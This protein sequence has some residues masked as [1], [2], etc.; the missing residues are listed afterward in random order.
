MEVVQRKTNIDCQKL[1]N[2]KLLFY[3][4]TKS[5]RIFHYTSIVGLEGILGNRTLRFTNIKYMNDKDEIIAG[6]DSMAKI[7]H[8][9]EEER[10]KLC[11]SFISHGMQTFVCCFSVEEDSLPMWNYY[12]KE[13]NNQGYNI[14][15]DD[16]QLVESILRGND[17]LNGCS[18]A[19]GIVDYSKD[20]DSEYSQ[21]I[22]REMLSA[23]DLAISKLFLTVA[24][25]AMVGHSSN[26]D[27]SSL[28]DWEKRIANTE[29]RQKLSDLP[30]YFYNGEKCRF[31]KNSS[32]DYLYF[33]KRDCFRQEREFRIVITVPDECLEG[34]RQKGIYKFRIGNGILIPFLELAFSPNVVKSITI[35]PTVKSDLVELSIQDFLNYCN[36]GVQDCSKFIK[37]SNVPVRF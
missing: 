11:S 18:L 28:V 26:V 20:N 6:L 16:K 5:R 37:H 7:C 10:E 3:K 27:E 15:F 30:I 29:G 36:F 31:E 34:L 1:Q 35:S 32:G 8:A 25:N 9:S 2:S 13:I 33:I 14:E 22:T 4:S 24:K 19:F 12:T 17:A 23:M 21:I